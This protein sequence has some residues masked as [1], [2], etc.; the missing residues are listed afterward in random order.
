MEK[1]YFETSAFNY[2]LE[3]I[4]FESFLNT[5]ELQR[6]RGRLL[7]V[8]PITLWEMMLTAD[9]PDFFIYSAQNLFS[10]QM[11]ASP[12]EMII[13]YLLNSYPANKVD[14]EIFSDLDMAEIWKR[15][16][17]DN[18]VTFNYDKNQLKQKTNLLW[19]ISKNLGSIIRY[20]AVKPHDEFLQ[21]IAIVVNTHFE[22]LQRD[23]FLPNIDS[24]RYDHRILYKVFVLIVFMIFILR[25]DIDNSATDKF[26][27]NIGL[28][29]DEA[30]EKLI[31]IFENYPELFK[32][33]PILEI[34]IMTYH[35]LQ[36]GKVNRGTIL[37]SLHMVYAPCVN[38]IISS[39]SNFV[40]LKLK[41]ERYKHK[42]KHVS[43]LNFRET[44]FISKKPM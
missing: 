9:N 20:P 19:G 21:S 1:V 32:C 25:I 14:Y 23:D 39:D 12:S 26:W 11:L 15:M 13:R 10:E 42:L 3:K 43:E 17:H 36:S 4:P 35:Q 37:D 8:S 24:A 18:S 38:T 6:M 16:A 33:G 5:R 22:C 2:L 7:Y 30:N 34:S 41:E 40:D 29:N 27:N 44:P 31:H 28:G